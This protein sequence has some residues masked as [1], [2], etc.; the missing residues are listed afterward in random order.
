M[1]KQIYYWV[2]P[3]FAESVGIQKLDG[4]NASMTNTV[5]LYCS[6]I[7]P[8]PCLVPVHKFIGENTADNND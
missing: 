4:L 8:D 6:K 2:P 3:R 1:Y 7:H 5:E